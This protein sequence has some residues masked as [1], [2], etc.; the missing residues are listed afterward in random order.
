[1]QAQ[2]EDYED[3]TGLRF[4]WNSFPANKQEEK[5]CVIP[6]SCLY[7]PLRPKTT[8]VVVQIPPSACRNCRAILS[9][10][11]G[12]DPNTGTWACPFCNTRNQLPP[13]EPAGQLPYAVS[14]EAQDIEYVVPPPETQNP[15]IFM[16][17]VDTCFGDDDEFK[18][19][20]DSIL[21]SLSMLPPD[22]LVGFI[23]FGRHVN[24][25][26]V[27]IQDF[28]SFYCFNGARKYTQAEI[29][30]NLELTGSNA[31]RLGVT[32]FVQQHAICEFNLTAL[33]ESLQ[34]DSFPTEKYHRRTLAT[35]CAVNVAVSLLSQTF[36]KTGARI[37]L[38]SGGPC[39]QGPGKIVGTP[40]KE[41]LRSH[42]DIEHDSKV[43]KQYKESSQFYQKLS[44][45]AAGNGHSI[46][47]FIGAYDQVGLSE[48]EALADKTGGVIVQSDSFS[49]AIFKRSLQKFLSPDEATG[50]ISFGLNA[51]M[52]VK[53]TRNLRIRGAIGHLTSLNN[54]NSSVTDKKPIG[55][56]GTDS[57]KLG[58]VWSHSAYS[59]FFEI[60]ENTPQADFSAI[61]FITTYQ[62]PDGTRRIHVTTTQR[63]TAPAGSADLITNFDQEV[64]AVVAAREAVWK[65]VADVT[66]QPAD[67]VRSLDR[68]LIDLCQHFASYRTND[69]TS[70]SLPPTLNLFPQ[71]MYHLRR[72]PFVQVFNSSPDET[73]YYRHCF[74]AEDS[75]NSLI[76][77]QPTLTS[78]E[79][80]KEPEPVVLD[81]T[82]LKPERILLLDTFFHI[83]IYHGA[84]VAEWK[85]LGYQDQSD[86][87]YFKEFLEKPRLEAADILVDRFPLPR[88]I[89]TE[90]GG[91]QARFLMSRL[92][93]STSYRNAESM[94]NLATSGVGDGESGAVIMTDDVSL[95][96]FM[97]Y[98]KKAVVKPE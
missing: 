96:T 80:D 17:V 41:P 10:C 78:Y 51:T 55:V 18:A 7:Q 69:A 90:E 42:H 50:M 68:V 36:P 85:R 4:P 54:K 16:Y 22:A 56:S 67:A 39:T 44:Q 62:H 61:Q 30:W 58:A 21:V 59:F 75:T 88:F 28:Q 37:L 87:A 60:A 84:V 83:L 74:L 72:S 92:S 26:E 15:P 29:S 95:Q 34:R 98:V 46:D 82:S 70:F 86:Y 8:P 23:T 11:C 45:T 3:L 31:S 6:V 71:F 52:Q 35:G 79:L 76:M 47:I 53:V 81:S 40:L 65:S 89:D 32:R 25:Y 14:P 63:P 97:E 9:P 1:M 13:S 48:M 19:L 2:F 27:G 5:R 33:V 43:E 24:V 57:W 49:S 94:M 77:I 73:S 91:S 64:A 66:N 20:T 12:V 38:F 93:P